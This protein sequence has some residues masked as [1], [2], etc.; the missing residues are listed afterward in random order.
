V[1]VNGEGIT[2]AEYQAEMASYQAANGTNLAT[3]WQQLVLDD[4]IDR[5]LLAQA[6]RQ[7]GFTLDE[8]ALQAR[9]DDL[10]RQAGGVQALANWIGAHGYSEGTFRLALARSAAAA[11]MSDQITGAVSWTADQVHARQILLYNSS[12]A[13]N[14]LSQLNNGADF[15][16]LA[17]QYDPATGGELGWFPKGYL[18]EPALEEAAFRLEPGKY[19]DVIQTSLGFHILLVLE[20]DPQHQLTSDARMALQQQALRKWIAERRSQSEIQILV[21]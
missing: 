6:A 7:A 16:A 2:L 13:T 20:R 4:L 9:M 10:A 15:A 3:H 14:V 8:A 11:W 19:S 1:R 18:T 12:D 5:T 17:A 21:P